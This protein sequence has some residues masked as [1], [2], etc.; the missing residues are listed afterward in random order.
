MQTTLARLRA[1]REEQS[2]FTLIELLIVVIILGILAAV[3]IF[4]IG[5]LQG[6]AST[7]ACKT[8]GRSVE[9]AAEAYYAQAG[10]YPQQGTSAANQTWLTGA[11]VVN[12]VTIGPFLKHV[13]S[14]SAYTITYTDGANN[15]TPPSVTGALTAGGACY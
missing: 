4:A 7:N 11:H 8:D 6:T 2:G 15:T 13:P 12:G 9:T 10:V 1:K 14:S 5:N 3:V